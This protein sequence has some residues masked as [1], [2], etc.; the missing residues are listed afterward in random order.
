MQHLQLPVF[1]SEDTSIFQR[2]WKTLLPLCATST[3]ARVYYWR[4]INLSKTLE[5]VVAIVCNIYSCPCL[6]L[7]IHQ[8]FKDFGK[9]CC[10]CMQH[11]QLPVF[12]TE[13]TSIFQR[14]WKT[15]LPLY[16]TSTAARVYY[17]IYINLSKTLENVVAIVWNI[18]SCPWLLLKI[19]QSFKDFGKRCCHCM[20]HLQLPVFI[21]E[22]TSIFQRLWKTLLPLYAT[23]T[24]ARVYFW[25]YINLSKTL[26]N[27]VAIVC[28][29]YSCP[30]LFLKIY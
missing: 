20:Q 21:T 19:H 8:S 3:A 16:A 15:F 13:D 18:Y 4:Y 25:R 1:I 22:D 29:I 12:I 10:H 5:N 9:R 11:L 23:S 26:E 2:L 17:W 7:K 6:F 27:V 28:N 30:C 14:L 24:A